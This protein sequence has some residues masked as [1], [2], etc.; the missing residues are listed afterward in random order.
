MTIVGCFP[1]IGLPYQ[2]FLFNRKYYVTIK[3]ESEEYN[4]QL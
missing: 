2:K 3:Q 1:G 4:W